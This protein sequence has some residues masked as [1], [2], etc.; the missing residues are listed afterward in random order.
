MR[1]RGQT[2]AA[3]AHDCR[4]AWPQWQPPA[5]P[6]AKTACQLRHALEMEA[7]VMQT[8]ALEM[9]LRLTPE[10]VEHTARAASWMMTW[11]RRGSGS[12]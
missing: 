10:M 1:R 4:H 3:A 2:R 5:Q 7:T 8:S 11:R 9:P 6:G 12:A